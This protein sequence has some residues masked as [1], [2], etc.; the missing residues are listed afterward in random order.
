MFTRMRERA[1]QRAETI[2]NQTIG[3]VII[4]P[5]TGT[6]RVDLSGDVTG[7][8]SGTVVVGLQHNAVS[9]AAP[10]DGQALVWDGDAEMWVPG[11]PG[12]PTGQIRDYSTL[13]NEALV[14]RG[15]S[16]SASSEAPLA[17]GGTMAA[18]NVIDENPNSSWESD[19]GLAPPYNAVTGAWVKIDLGSAKA[20]TYVRYHGGG[21]NPG[22]PWVATFQSSTDNSTWTDRGTVTLGGV[23]HYDTGYMDLGGSVTARYWRVILTTGPDPDDGSRRYTFSAYTIYLY[24]GT[25]LIQAPGH[26]IEDEGTPLTQRSTLNFMGADVAAADAGGKTVVT[27]DGA[28]RKSLVDAKGDLLA[29][30]AND[31][32]ARVAVGTNGQVL[33]ADSAQTAGVKWATPGSGGAP[34]DATYVT[35][36]SDGTLTNEVL[37]SD[38]AVSELKTRWELVTDGSVPELIWAGPA[39]TQDLIYAEVTI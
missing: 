38:V 5:G 29:G 2:V 14:G 19:P 18:G 16:A 6:A 31:T 37:L 25:P 30:T 33:T 1:E 7:P 34:D 13:V 17:A 10:A 9:S 12:D 28:V 3:T 39:G 20:I 4:D 26:V 24:S 27:I 21:G 11:A 23:D 36:T 15:A 35:R 32:V 22:T 8:S